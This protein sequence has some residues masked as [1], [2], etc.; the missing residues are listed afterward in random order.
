[1]KWITA[2]SVLIALLV[3]TAFGV[4]LKIGVALPPKLEDM[5]VDGGGLEVTNA[6][7]HIFVSNQT[8]R[9]IS[10]EAV[11]D[12]SLAFGASLIR[13]EHFGSYAIGTRVGPGMHS[14]E[15]M[16]CGRP[17]VTN[18]FTF[19]TTSA[20]TNFISISILGDKQ[21]GYRFKMKQSNKPLGI[22]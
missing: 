14:V 12:G 15:V 9:E 18:A 20:V 3:L 16:V 21:T 19:T 13:D 8:H 2:V 11:L 1:V 5:T 6:N 4:V 22:I 10:V 7:L 17:P